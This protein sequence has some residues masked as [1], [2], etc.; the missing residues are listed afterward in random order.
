MSFRNRLDV[1]TNLI[2]H[3]SAFVNNP[4]SPIVGFWLRSVHVRY[5]CTLELGLSSI[6]TFISV[7]KD[8]GSYR[9]CKSCTVAMQ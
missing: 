7:K 2:V 5:A 4:V 8:S 9:R 1:E 3:F 6:N